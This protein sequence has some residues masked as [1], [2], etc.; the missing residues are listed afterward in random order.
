MAQHPAI[1]KF[2]RERP[3]TTGLIALV[4]SALL[5]YWW[6]FTPLQAIRNHEESIQLS[7]AGAMCAFI[8]LIFGMILM[9]SGP[10]FAKALFPLPGDENEAKKENTLYILSAILVLSSLVFFFCF[11]YY[12]STLGY[13]S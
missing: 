11:K 13:S 9:I 4:M 12:L 1:T 3:R 8:F 10:Y 6:I 5:I 2:G 7:F